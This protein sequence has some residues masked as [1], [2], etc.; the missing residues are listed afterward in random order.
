[1]T[2]NRPYLVRAL[3]E[4]ILDNGLTPHLLVDASRPG[5]V[6]PVEF[7]QD[8]KIVLNIGPSAVRALVLGNERISFNARFGGVAMDVTLPAEAV[9]GIYARENGRGMLFP[10]EEPQTTGASGEEP[11]PPKPPRDRP[12]LKVVK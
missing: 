5:S 9:M 11:E 8:G 1:M 4:W 3:Y 6:L 2:S 7:V 10:D 12:S